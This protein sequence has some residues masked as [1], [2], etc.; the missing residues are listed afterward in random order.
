MVWVANRQL[1]FECWLSNSAN[2]GFPFVFIPRKINHGI[3]MKTARSIR[4]MTD[5]LPEEVGCYQLVESVFRDIL[6]RYGYDEI[7]L[8]MVEYAE[9]FKRSIGCETD[10]V[11]KEMYTFL[12]RN[13]DEITLRPE[14]T[15]PMI[16]AAISN[17]LLNNLPSK[18]DY[19]PSLHIIN[20]LTS[21]NKKKIKI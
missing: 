19:K 1:W 4:G 18:F 16:R 14:Y 8:P 13:G 7:R 6:H 17:G 3:S 9:L 21:F 10:I 20:S 12:D 11:E 15:T 2:P 5:I